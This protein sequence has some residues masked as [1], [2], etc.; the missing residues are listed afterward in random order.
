VLQE[1]VNDFR[2]L[3]PLEVVGDAG[4]FVLGGQK[5]RALLALLLL[6]AGEVVATERL[7]TELWGERPPKTATTSLQ[8]FVSQLRKLFGSDLV[9]TKPPGYVLRL[10]PGQLDLARFEGLVADARREEPRERARLL[11]EALA[12]W[13][14]PP[15]ADL[16][17]ETFAQSEIRRLEELRL[18]ALETRIDADLEL[19]GSSELVPELETLVAQHPLRERLRHQHM[20]ALYR[21]GRQADALDAYHATRRAL[22]DELGIEPSPALQQLYA[23]ILRQESGLQPEAAQGSEED[24]LMDVVKALVGGRLVLV[25]GP[26]VNLDGPLPDPSEI[27]ARLAER[28]DCPSDRCTDLARAAEYVALT[29]GVG[30]L[31]DELHDLLDRDHEPGPVHRF[32]AALASYLRDQGQPRQLVVTTSFDNALER[33]LREAD[34]EIDVVS[35]VAL[36]RFGGKFVHLGHDGATTVIDLPNAYD[37]LSLEART[38]VLKIHGQVD[39]TP[40]R[41]SESFVVAEDDHIDYLAQAE[42]ASV[43]PVT[44]AAKLRRSHF[45]FLGYPLEDWSLRVFLHRVWGRDKVSYR[46]WAVQPGAGRVE[47]ELWRQRG[48]EVVDAPL[49]EYVTAVERRLAEVAR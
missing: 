30:P 18:D 41:D 23:S 31:Y 11:R 15:L 19:G 1:A 21:A 36:G 20:L 26:G 33:A 12:L 28:F 43:V 27:T 6:R 24:H 42:L 9:E 13:R 44:I 22:V 48:I 49:Q 37:G 35:Y 34:E 25:L 8:N 17:Y 46:S 3:G 7:V 5:Q 2:I 38:V 45:L 39:R 10:E 14:G 40:T 4:P 32:A 29:H 47:R 16:A